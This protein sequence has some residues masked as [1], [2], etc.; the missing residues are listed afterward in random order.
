MRARS[1]VANSA[2]ISSAARLAGR[3]VGIAC[4][5]SWTTRALAVRRAATGSYVR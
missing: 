5:S 2:R 3:S 4:S 1:P